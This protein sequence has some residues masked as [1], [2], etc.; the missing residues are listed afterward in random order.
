QIGIR[1]TRFVGFL[2]I[3]VLGRQQCKVEEELGKGGV[4]ESSAHNL[5]DRLTSQ[6]KVFK[7]DER[8]AEPVPI[9][10]TM[11]KEGISMDEALDRILER[12]E[13]MEA[14]RRQEEKFNQILQKLEEVEAR[15]SK[16]AEE[17]IASIRATTA[18]LKATSP[19]APMAPPT[20]AC[21][22]CLTE[23]PNNNLTWATVSS[24]HI[25]EDTAPT[26]AWE[27]GD[28]K[29]KG[30]APCVV[31]KDSLEVTP[32]MCSTKCSG[33]TVEPDLTVAVVVTSATTAAAS[34]ELVATGNTIGATYINNLDHPKVTHAKCLM[35]DLGSN[36]GDN[37]TMVT[38]QTLVDMTKGVFAPDA[39]IEVSSPRKIAEMDLVIVMPTGCSMLFFD[40]GASELLPV[41]RHVMWQLLLEQC[42]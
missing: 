15:R 17:T 4:Q 19:I 29:D 10:S 16:A 32:T 2:V 14:N 8:I 11:N 27:L 41:R 13:L 1:A 3:E 26:V 24:S 37:Q 22:K 23:C 39:T 36:S 42:K 5:F 18:V 20:P 30:H 9:K 38:F 40:K 6:H 21:T 31:T 35:L 33:P 7:D 12:F 28:N 25:S 34:M